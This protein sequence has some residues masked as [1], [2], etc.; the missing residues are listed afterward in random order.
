M[1][2]GY[3]HL[4]A[5]GAVTTQ[6][7]WEIAFD[8]FQ[9][10]MLGGDLTTMITGQALGPDLRV[11]L[12]FFMARREAVETRFSALYE[13][14]RKEPAVRS[15]ERS[16]DGRYLV[17]LSGVQDEISLDAERLQVLRTSH[18]RPL[19]LVLN[20]AAQHALLKRRQS[21][22][23][24]INWLD[25]GATL[26]IHSSGAGREPLRVQAPRAVRVRWNGAAA[27]CRID[28]ELRVI[29]SAANAPQS[30]R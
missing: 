7:P 13:P 22:P 6:A 9:I 29:T 5:A 12:P 3:Q 24:E 18:G 21:T 20:G 23:I 26:D 19:R 16:A 15:F 8:H 14:F 28:G 4:T 25:D 27:A 17:K 11:P 1:G 2:N 30:C 10:Y